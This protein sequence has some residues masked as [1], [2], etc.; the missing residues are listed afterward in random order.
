VDLLRPNA[1]SPDGRKIAFES[2]RSGVM[3]IWVANAD[4]SDARL[5]FGDEKYGTSGSPAW[6]PDG[7]WIAFDT[8][9]DGNAEIYVISAEG[10]AVR[11]LTKNPSD[12]VIPCWSH[13]GKWIYFGS[14]RTGRPE[15]LKMPPEGGDA[16]QLTHDGGWAGVE[17]RDGKFLYFTRMRPATGGST[18]AATS[19][20]NNPLLRIPVTGGE[21]TPVLDTVGERAWAV[22]D[23]GIWF[24]WPA[25]P[26]RTELR[27][28]SSDTHRVS[29]VA[30]IAKPATAG[31]DLSADGRTLLYGQ[32][33]S[34]RSEIILVE[35][36]K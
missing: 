21:E 16:I 7:Q 8:R 23:Q 3:S 6:S 5:L 28:F 31:L 24:L 29:T 22:A 18:Y 17:S 25:G 10:G 4:G 15:M 11:R 1:F 12:D 9:K 35:G 14:T 33:E 32:I 13:D 20:T 2:D 34:Q 30:T 36:F 26:S 19:G 27:F